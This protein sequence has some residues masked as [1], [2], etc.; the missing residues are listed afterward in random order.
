MEKE[1]KVEDSE[2]EMEDSPYAAEV[3]E[4]RQE[5]EKIR[6]RLNKWWKERIDCREEG[7]EK[8]YKNKGNNNKLKENKTRIIK[9]VTC[10]R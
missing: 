4:K 10:S 8:K 9:F 5:W 7:G 1:V 2:G 3:G 6:M